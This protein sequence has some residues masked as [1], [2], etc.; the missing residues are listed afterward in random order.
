VQLFFQ[1]VISG[2]SIGAVYAL[3]GV[4][5]N[6][7][8]AAT[9]VFNLAQGQILMLG[10]MFTYTV[11]QVW[12]VNT[13]LAI[14]IA[15]IAAG[16]VNVLVDRTC[17]APLRNTGHLFHG[18]GT[19]VTTLGA[20]IVIVNL[21]TMHYGAE[22]QPFERFFPVRGW[23]VGGVIITKQQVLMVAGAILIIGAYQMFI[24]RTRW[25]IGLSAMSEDS[26]AAALRGVPIAFGRSLAFFLGGVISALGG[27]LIGPVTAAD[28][29]LGYSFGLKGFVAVAIGGFGSA[30]GALAGGFVLGITEAM[31]VTYSNDGYRTFAGL[32]LMLIILLVRPQ[33]I[34]GRVSLRQV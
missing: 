29:N 1:A 33:G 19:L 12:G 4:G 26:E 31:M 16:L 17:V 20:S 28:P 5:Y 2:L 8:F 22:A 24:D 14:A 21:A 3:V 18:I 32:A 11:R 30:T 34:M 7:I 15:C 13:V 10:V 6:V 25:G 23:N 27:A 9:R